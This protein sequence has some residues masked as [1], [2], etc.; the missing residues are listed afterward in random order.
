MKF[1]LSSFNEIATPLLEKLAKQFP[2]PIQVDTKKCEILNSDLEAESQLLK[3]TLHFLVQNTYLA[4]QPKNSDGVIIE[5]HLT[6]KGLTLLKI[7]FEQEFKKSP[8]VYEQGK[9]GC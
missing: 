7:N 1:D 4:T 3:A 2:L 5:Y 8:S 9:T 6:E